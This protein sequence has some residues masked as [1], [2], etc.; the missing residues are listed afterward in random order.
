MPDSSRDDCSSRTA[1]ANV[2]LTHV[3]RESA[4][5]GQG[6]TGTGETIVGEAWAL[7]YVVICSLCSSLRQRDA[8]PASICRIKLHLQPKQRLQEGNGAET[9]P[10][11]GPGGWTWDFSRCSRR[12]SG[13]GHANASKEVTAPSGVAVDSAGRRRAGISPRPMNRDLR[14]NGRPDLEKN[15]GEDQ[16]TWRDA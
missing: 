4:G 6:L 10:L 11:P 9:P 12:R 1:Q 13:Q 8:S 16:H 3:P 14:C 7:V 2:P 15:A 5:E